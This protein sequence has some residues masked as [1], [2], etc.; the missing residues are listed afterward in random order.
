[1]MREFSYVRATDAAQALHL[2]NVRPHAKYLGGGT[3]LVDLMREA[4]ETPDALSGFTAAV[5]II[6]ADRFW[7]RGAL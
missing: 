5:A 6:I 4:M 7:A 2:S 3:N 1:M